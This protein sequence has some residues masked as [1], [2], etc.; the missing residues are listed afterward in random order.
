MQ[1][2]VFTQMF[3]GRAEDQARK[4]LPRLSDAGVVPEV[5]GWVDGGVVMR[6]GLPLP[7][8]ITGTGPADV[9]ALRPLLIDLLERLR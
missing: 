7:N 9:V 1:P 4:Y 3:G 2:E 5:L 6:R 8:W